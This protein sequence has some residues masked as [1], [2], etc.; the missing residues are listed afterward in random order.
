MCLFLDSNRGA[1]QDSQLKKIPVYL[2]LGLSADSQLM[3]CNEAF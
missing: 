3:L 2:K 1:L